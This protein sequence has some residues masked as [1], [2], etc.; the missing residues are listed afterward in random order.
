MSTNSAAAL[1]A[2]FSLVFWTVGCAGSGP[3]GPNSR[4]VP[5]ED[6]TLEN[7]FSRWPSGQQYLEGTGTGRPAPG[8]RETEAR[9]RAA[10]DEAAIEAQRQLIVQLESLVGRD[11]IRDLLRKAEVS[12]L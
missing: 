11:R 7:I 9:R 6:L 3:L 2:G 8:Q 5:F 4:G 12:R 1:L 10:R